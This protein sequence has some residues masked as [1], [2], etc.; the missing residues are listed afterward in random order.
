MCFAH[1]S[2]NLFASHLP[3]FVIIITNYRINPQ[4]NPGLALREFE[5]LLLKYPA[6][7]AAIHGRAR[8][9][10]ALADETQDRVQVLQSIDVHE[11]LLVNRESEMEDS[12]FESVAATCLD[13]LK[14]LGE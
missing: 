4:K 11:N 1:S 10:D 9:L 12:L 2:I 3:R 7:F 13:R 8:A 6:S 14:M 5:K